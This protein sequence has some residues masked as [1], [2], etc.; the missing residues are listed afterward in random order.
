M[1]KEIIYVYQDCALCGS[2][3]QKLRHFANQH[4]FEI[5]KL[6]FTTDL[7][8]VL[9]HE[10]VF[11]H[12]IGAMPFFT[13]GKKFSYK[14]SDFIEEEPKKVEKKATRTRKTKKVK[15]KKQDESN[16]KN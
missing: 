13:D 9:I 7:A 1:A 2:K 12:G 5:K 10:A 8:K 14:L 6:G 3:G 4:G 15:E 16:Q 11:E